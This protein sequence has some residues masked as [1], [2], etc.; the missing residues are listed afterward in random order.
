MFGKLG[1]FV[2]EIKQELKKVTWP[3]RDEVFEST[4]VV[5]TTT[6]IMA[7]FVGVIDF[8]LSWIMRLLLR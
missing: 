8:A 1:N 5:I 7:A 3:T 6:L 4:A 2:D